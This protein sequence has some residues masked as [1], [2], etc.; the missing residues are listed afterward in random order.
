MSS[1]INRLRTIDATVVKT[2]DADD[3]LTVSSAGHWFAD[4]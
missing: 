2:I 4:T 1:A 3:D